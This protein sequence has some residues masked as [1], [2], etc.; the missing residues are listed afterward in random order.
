MLHEPSRRR[1]ERG[2]QLPYLGSPDVEDDELAGGSGSGS[3]GRL[4][5]THRVSS[6]PELENTDKIQDVTIERAVAADPVRDGRSFSFSSRRRSA[7]LPPRASAVSTAPQWRPG[8]ASDSRSG[9]KVLD[10]PVSGGRRSRG[11]PR[12]LHLT[13]RCFPFLPPRLSAF[14]SGIRWRVSG[15]ARG[16]R[17]G[18]GCSQGR[19]RRELRFRTGARGEGAV[20]S[21]RDREREESS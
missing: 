13:P 17:N 6:S 2:S 12:H 15:S 11:R 19:G 16:R 20:A 5:R 18:A 10:S 3:G 21:I 14:S 8:G 7:F 1:G 4:L 9:G